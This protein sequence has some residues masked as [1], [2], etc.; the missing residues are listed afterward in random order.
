MKSYRKLLLGFTVLSVIAALMLLGCDNPFESDSNGDGIAAPS[1]SAPGTNAG[2]DDFGEIPSGVTAVQDEA[3]ADQFLDD[4]FGAGT[5]GLGGLS[6]GS[7]AT[8]VVSAQSDEEP[9]LD[10]FLEIK[11]GENSFSA[12]S[13]VTEFDFD[14]SEIGEAGTISVSDFSVN[15]SVSETETTTQEN[16]TASVR[17]AFRAALEDIDLGELEVPKGLIT[18][19]ANAEVRQSANDDTGVA[20]VSYSISIAG[21]AGMTVVDD[22]K[23]AHLLITISASDSFSITDDKATIESKL[24]DR[25]E[26]ATITTTV[27]VYGENTDEP[28]AKR[29][30]DEFLKDL[31]L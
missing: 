3:Q 29:E 31:D 6:V 26:N 14:L 30:F 1:A 7:V 16:L 13:T 24:L 11:E 17:T 27:S 22:G 9:D 2:T 4:L 25:L 10:E 23:G 20:S 12:K 18:M 5:E 15:I 19:A 8:N 21:S 28:L